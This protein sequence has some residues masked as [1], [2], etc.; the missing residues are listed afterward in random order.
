MMQ[1]K[2]EIIPV[3]KITLGERLRE[4]DPNW[5][6]VLASSIG[7]KG[8]QQPV[9]VEETDDGKG[10]KLVI[11]GHRLE[12]IRSLEHDE[13]RAVVYPT[14]ALDESQA[15]LLELTENLLRFDLTAL[16][17]ALHLKSLKDIH[18]A[19]NPHAGRGGD[20]KSDA[21]KAELANQTD[22]VSVWFGKPFSE[23]T[24]EATGF[25]QRTVYRSISIA[26]KLTDHSIDKLCLTEHAKNQ[27]GLIAL[28][29][30]NADQQRMVCNMLTRAKQPVATLAD[31]I[32]EVAGRPK[33][34]ECASFVSS[35][36]NSYRRL[37]L[38]PQH[39]DAVFSAIEE[40]FLKWHAKRG[41]GR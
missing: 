20:R 10:F 41:G 4:I 23:A 21:A 32:N 18:L 19:L 15:K 35:F 12:A 39:Q 26:E 22:N 6:A 28:S 2:V 40:D 25:D 33:S 13:I 5:V 7:E 11:G 37:K 38:K 9:V 30:L 36:V 3:S 27:S 24:A 1:S 31:A 14:G 17:R 29:K 16:D 34:D 8:L